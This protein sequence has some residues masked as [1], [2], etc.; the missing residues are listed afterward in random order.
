MQMSGGGLGHALNASGL[1]FTGTQLPHWLPLPP[2][3]HALTM[4]TLTWS[5]LCRLPVVV[6]TSLH[7]WI[8]S[9]DG[10]RPF[11]F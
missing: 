10:P 5:V 9:H 4:Y 7:V 1:R 3:T 8:G 6:Y 2:Q 11:R